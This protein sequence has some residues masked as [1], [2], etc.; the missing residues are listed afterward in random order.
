MA[1]RLFPSGSI[2][3]SKRVDEPGAVWVTVPASSTTRVS[4]TVIGASLIGLMLMVMVTVFPS[5]VPSLAL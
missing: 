3:L 1:V 2:S 4:L 5:S